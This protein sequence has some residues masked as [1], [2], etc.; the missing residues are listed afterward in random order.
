MPEWGEAELSVF[1]K[2]VVLIRGTLFASWN[3]QTHEV[4]ERYNDVKCVHNHGETRSGG[5]VQRAGKDAA[6]PLPF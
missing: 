6:R 2:A 1:D 4:H 5:S 3:A